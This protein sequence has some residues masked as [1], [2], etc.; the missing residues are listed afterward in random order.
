MTAASSYILA[1]KV[2]NKTKEPIMMVV[3]V[4]VVVVDRVYLPSCDIICNTSCRWIDSLRHRRLQ[5]KKTGDLVH[6]SSAVDVW[7]RQRTVTAREQSY[8]TFTKEDCLRMV[9]R[10]ASLSFTVENNHGL[11]EGS[12]DF[13]KAVK[14]CGYGRFHYGLMFLCGMMFLCVAF[15][16]GINAYILPSAECDLKL[17]SEAK[18]LL[19]VAF[20]IGGVISSIFWGIFADAYGRRNVLLVTLMIDSV[21]SV[22][23]S[24]SQSFNTLIIFRAINGFTIGAPGSLIYTYLGEFHSEKDRAKS[25]CYV[26]FFWTLAWLIL[27]GLAWIIIPLPISFEFNG[28]SYNSWRLLLVVI[29]V[30]TFIVALVTLTY[31]ESPKFLVS[32]GKTDEALRILREIYVINTGAKEEDYPVKVLLSEATVTTRK[33]GSSLS[34]SD[35]FIVLLK[36]IWSQIRAITSWPLLKYALLCWSIYFM[37]MFGYYGLGLWLPEL[38]NRFENYQKLYPNVTV[39]VCEL[40]YKTEAFNHSSIKPS[41]FNESVILLPLTN[42]TEECVS[43]MD[44][45]V[46]INALTINAVC[47]LGNIASG[48]F[49]D[50]V[51]RRT[52]PVTTMLIAGVFGFATY[53]VKSSVQI[54]IVTCLFSLM[55]ATANFVIGSVVV[56]I[57]PTHVGAIAICMMTC[58]GRIGAVASNLAFGMLL[59][60]SCE[61]PIFLVG[62]IV[63]AG[64]LLGLLL[65]LKK[66]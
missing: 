2:S 51:G 42:S 31:S 45:R 24:F 47:L 54:L 48:Y 58:F 5:A 13:E 57:F 55:I 66:S 22:I 65:P 52:M 12:V 56:D 29:A 41:T 9:N 1:R 6:V 4:V 63:V 3:V 26:G 33:E 61:V 34:A 30:P 32:R 18:G 20:L 16:N 60:I 53:F 35:L 36:N 21:I 38:F 59:D 62:S 14:F 39:T 49:A 25:I 17:S 15:Q 27:P 44:K 50:R 8:S 19:N 37:N 43:T 10:I 64:G 46:F 11:K 28:M 40:I 7:D 23:S